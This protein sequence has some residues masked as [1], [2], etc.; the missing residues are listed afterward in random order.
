MTTVCV[1]SGGGD[2]PGVNALFRAFVH[3]AHRHGIKL[4]GCRYG[5]EGLLDPEGLVPLGI[6]DVR[7][8]LPRGGS[9][10][11]C[12][13]R[14]NPFFVKTT[15]S[16]EP[17]DMGPAIVDRLR[18]SGIDAL[19]LVGGDGTM[20]AASRFMKLGLGTIGVP[21]TI[22]NDLGETDLT[23][24]FDTAVGSVTHALDALHSTA[25]AHARVM[26]VEVMGRNAGWIALHAGVAGGADVVLIPEIPYRIERVAAKIREREALGLR[27]SIVVIAEGARPVGEKVLEIQ[28]ARP[29]LLPRLGGAGA[30]LVAELEALHLGHE[31]RLTVLGHLQRGGSPSAFD[32]MLATQMGAYAAALCHEGR[33]GRMVAW[34][35]GRVTSIALPAEDGLHK[36]VDPRGSLATA[37]R[38]VGVELGG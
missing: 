6:A 7:G 35:D 12:S 9:I 3:A 15:D 23:C 19:V 22:D 34:R 28:A 2:A 33:F 13:T 1:L 8:I 27:F 11:G 26:V 10:L 21:K 16:P 29:G 20:L 30:R 37:A 5:F 38:V 25:E 36:S 14:I 24:G 32:R 17:R 31:V 4:V 18:S